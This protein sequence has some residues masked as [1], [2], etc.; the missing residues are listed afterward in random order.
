MMRYVPYFS[1]E[2]TTGIDTSAYDKLPD[3]IEPEI[4]CEA[5]EATLMHIIVKYGDYVPFEENR[6]WKIPIPGNFDILRKKKRNTDTSFVYV[7]SEAMVAIKDAIGASSMQQVLRIF[8]RAIETMRYRFNSFK[9]ISEELSVKRL[10][11]LGNDSSLLCLDGLGPVTFTNEEVFGNGLGLRSSGDYRVLS[12]SFRELFCRRCYIYDCRS[13]GVQQ[14]LP[15]V[16]EDP[17]PPFPSP[18]P[19]LTLPTNKLMEIPED[20]QF[21]VLFGEGKGSGRSSAPEEK[22]ESK[23]EAGREPEVVEPEKKKRRVTRSSIQAE[24]EEAQ[25]TAPNSAVKPQNEC[26]I[27]ASSNAQKAPLYRDYLRR[28]FKGAPALL[29]VEKA[30]IEK[31]VTIYGPNERYSI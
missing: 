19:A 13:H 21:R 27:N 17:K 6:F 3:E 20:S 24:A 26:D 31:L 8:D 1:D 29:S 5:R 23:S 9:T 18:F 30:I 14:P 15:R 16:R 25:T 7:P 4:Y 2:D 28:S 11:S 10:E 12:E 22:V